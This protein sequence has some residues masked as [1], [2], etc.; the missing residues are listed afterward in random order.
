MRV[1]APVWVLHP[2]HGNKPVAEGI[3]GSRPPPRNI[4]GSIART[5][6]MELCEDDGKQTVK[7]TKVLRKSTFVMHP[8][9]NP[10]SQFIDGYATPPA[11]SNTH[12]VWSTR[13]LQYMV[14]E[15]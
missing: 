14:G 1:G 8:E 10:L 12:A 4:E 13:Y 15:E 3:A 5:L 9:D 7:V 11:D 2:A 6:L